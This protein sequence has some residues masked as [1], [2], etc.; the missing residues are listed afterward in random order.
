[1][2]ILGIDHV[3]VAAPADCELAARRF[4]GE[5]LGL[6][7]LDKPE[8]L[9]GRG[10]VWFEVGTQQLHVGVAESF[11]PATKAHPAL[12]VGADGLDRLA[13]RLSA[14]GSPVVWDESIPGA[15]RF[16]TE[17]PWGNRIE[18]LAVTV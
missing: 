11:T 15:R 14:A 13:A 10:G 16:F 6:G 8:A 3:Q 5:L 4:Y 18:L 17:D 1:V 7:E 12:R 9:A 2:G